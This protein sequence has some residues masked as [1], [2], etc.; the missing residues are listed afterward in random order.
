MLVGALAGFGHVEKSCEICSMGKDI[1]FRAETF[2][3]YSERPY[4]EDSKLQGTLHDH[5]EVSITDYEEKQQDK[6]QHYDPELSFFLKHFNERFDFVP[7][8]A[9]DEVRRK[10]WRRE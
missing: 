2:G 7:L 3:E 1:R 6:N 9:V 4:E 10:Q 8:D 5:T